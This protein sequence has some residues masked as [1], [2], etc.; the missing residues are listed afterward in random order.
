MKSC[1]ICSNICFW[2]IF[3]GFFL[4]LCVFFSFYF[5]NVC[6]GLALRFTWFIWMDDGVFLPFARIT[7]FKPLI[8][9]LMPIFAPLNTFCSFRPFPPFTIT[10]SLVF[11]IC[12]YGYTNKKGFFFFPWHF[13]YGSITFFHSIIH[14]MLMHVFCIRS[15][16]SPIWHEWLRTQ[17]RVSFVLSSFFSFSVCLMI[18][19]ITENG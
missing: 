11:A 17:E 14:G 10:I 7:N 6:A 3:H 18:A 19:Y 9:K 8:R 4:V 16:L 2:R 15:R 12:A 13:F 1:I 5:L